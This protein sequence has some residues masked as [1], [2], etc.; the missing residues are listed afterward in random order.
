MNA[1]NLIGQTFGNL[2]VISR[3]KNSKSGKA[4]WKCLCSCGNI[5]IVTSTDLVSGHTRSCGCKRYE[6]HNATHGMTKTDLHN[7]WCQMRQR[8]GNPQCKAYQHYGAEGVSVC[9]EWN[10]FANFR[11][12]SLANG[13][14]EGLSLDRINNEKGYSPDN[15]RWITWE[16]QSGNRRNN[17]N[18]TYRGK[19]Q[20]LRAWCS[21]LGLNYAVIRQR[22]RRDGYTFEQAIASKKYERRSGCAHR[23]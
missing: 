4:R 11:N 16:E 15:C 22:I 9:D 23:K 13:Y 12:W 7:K 1:K 2:T 3:V 17:L 10:S 19:T 21:E 6:S 8:C 14:R 18:F 5:S 20:N